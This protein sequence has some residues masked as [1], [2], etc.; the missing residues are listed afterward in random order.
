MKKPTSGGKKPPAI[1]K[2]SNNAKAPASSFSE[3]SPKFG[4][5][6]FDEFLWLWRQRSTYVT[7]F[8]CSMCHFPRHLPSKQVDI[9]RYTGS[10]KIGVTSVIQMVSLQFTDLA[11]TETVVT[12]QGRPNPML[13]NTCGGEKTLAKRKTV[14]KT[15]FYWISRKKNARGGK[16]MAPR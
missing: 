13:Y 6:S 14:S 10:W 2:K 8:L 16:E 12:N 11:T 4:E 7:R 3:T 9:K 5:N 15:V 1:T